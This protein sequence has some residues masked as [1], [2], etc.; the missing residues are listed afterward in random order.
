MVGQF[1]WRDHPWRI[2]DMMDDLK[3]LMVLTLMTDKADVYV[4]FKTDVLKN[5]HPFY[6]CLV[7]MGKGSPRNLFPEKERSLIEMYTEIHK[8]QPLYGSGPDMFEIAK[9]REVVP[10]SVASVVDFG[11]GKSMLADALFQGSFIFRYDP[12]ID[13]VSQAPE[14]Y[15]PYEFG[16]CTDVLEHIPESELPFERLKKLAKDWYFT[17]HTGPANQKLPDGTNAHKTQKPKEWWVERLGGKIVWEEGPRFG[18]L[19]S[20]S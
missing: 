13:A 17:I 11:C 6:R 8:K 5:K 16:L 1:N 7:Q 9:I 18:L 2:G 20:F 12:A 4:G 15:G 3:A 19:T 10:S 14:H